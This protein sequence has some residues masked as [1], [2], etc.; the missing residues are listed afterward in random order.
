LLIDEVEM[1]RQVPIFAR[2]KPTK[3]KLLAFASERRKYTI[4]QDV[5]RQGEAGDA[6]YVVLSGTADIMVASANGELKVAEVGAQS[7]VG[8][9][10]VL[11]GGVR[12]ASVRATSPVEVLRI[13][14]EHF[15]E[16]VNEF[17]D[18]ALEIM[19]I[20]AERLTHTTADLTAARNANN[21]ASD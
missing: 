15:L 8:E 11:C 12:T 7:I 17:P 19:R 20:L 9:I 5:C 21:L 18:V 13:T 1:L 2:I 6:A 10:A 16:L 3:L 4:G 14:K